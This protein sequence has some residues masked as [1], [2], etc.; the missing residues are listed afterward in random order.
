MDSTS[1][2]LTDSTAPGV[3]YPLPSDV[4]AV[5]G[6]TSLVA[7]TPPSK[8]SLR[9][10]RVRHDETEARLKESLE[11]ICKQTS[12]RSSQAMNLNQS[13][14][15]TQSRQL[16]VQNTKLRM[17]ESL[18]CGVRLKVD[19]TGIPPDAIAVS[20]VTYSNITE[21]RQRLKVYSTS[22]D[23]CATLY[24]EQIASHVSPGSLSCWVTEDLT[25]IYIRERSK[26]CTLVEFSYVDSRDDPG[27]DE[28]C[29]VRE[30]FLPVVRM[31]EDER[32]YQ[33]TL[34]VP[35][36]FTFEDLSVKTVDDTL[37]IKGCKA[38]EPVTPGRIASNETMNK[39]GGGVESQRKRL[40]ECEGLKSS[41]G[42]RS[43]DLESVSRSRKTAVVERPAQL[44]TSS[45]DV[46]DIHAMTSDDVKHY[47]TSSR[48]DD[49]KDEG[50]DDITMEGSSS[51][52]EVQIGD[53]QMFRDIKR[54]LE[55]LQSPR[56]QRVN[57]GFS[58][59]SSQQQGTSFKSDS[60]NI[61]LEKKQEASYNSNTRRIRI[62]LGESGDDPHENSPIPTPEEQTNTGE[63]PVEC[64]SFRV[65]LN[66][67]DGI[68]SRSVC[69]WLSVNQILLVKAALS[70][71][72]RRM[73]CNF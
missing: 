69:A 58:L 73:T 31:N 33:I 28:V 50:Y 66:L 13:N 57:K 29:E 36:D 4:I 56:A 40:S 15:A 20:M 38:E 27:V 23:S 45:D 2:W 51:V 71:S 7:L 22:D 19:L 41:D 11:M 35:R 3:M 59:E 47:E 24:D 52:D 62:H 65:A 49:V 14:T 32:L 26:E 1:Y 5:C 44:N 46:E 17:K 30:C 54:E 53:V 55:S 16:S 25:S 12:P 6:V 42:M 9:P 64:V 61:T 43:E 8:P 37:I 48:V 21:S 68:D 10:L 18:K 72:S 67:V 39:Q 34:K 63:V 70:A 60:T